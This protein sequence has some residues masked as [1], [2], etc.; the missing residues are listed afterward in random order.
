MKTHADLQQGADTAVDFRRSARR[1]GDAGEDLEERALSGAVAPDDADDLAL[2][3]L[4]RDVF[5][6]P[7]ARSSGFFMARSS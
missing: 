6:I 5:E 7:L 2:P 3:D 1:F 4:Q